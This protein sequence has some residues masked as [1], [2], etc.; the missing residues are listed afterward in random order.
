VAAA[1]T[2]DAAAG[3]DQ[4]S[5]PALRVGSTKSRLFVDCF[6]AAQA[7]RYTCVAETPE[8]RIASSATLKIGE[9][10]FSL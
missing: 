3:S 9:L 5:A 2:G 4:E 7:G 6:S 8:G 1:G 10:F